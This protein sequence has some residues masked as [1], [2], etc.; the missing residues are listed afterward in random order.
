M[1]TENFKGPVAF[2]LP[3]FWTKPALE[4]SSL[5]GLFLD[6]RPSE[7]VSS[8]GFE[9]ATLPTVHS[10]DNN[11][12]IYFKVLPTR[13][14]LTNGNE[15]VLLNRPMVYSKAA[16]WDNVQAWFNGGA[17]SPTAFVQN[18]QLEILFD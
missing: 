7:P 2:F 3:T 1:N 17:V 14:P 13:Y 18:G 5:E 12:N 16:M 11:G 10:T 9:T 15:S 6:T 4:D 8:Y